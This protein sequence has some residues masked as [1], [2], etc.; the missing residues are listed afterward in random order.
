[1][2]N[3]DNIDFDL[4]IFGG[5]GDLTMRKLLPALY[6][7][8][9]DG[10][11]PKGRVI[12]VARTDLSRDSF[13]EQATRAARRYI[14]K[15]DQE[16]WSDFSQRLEYLCI[17][18][19]DI[20]QFAHLRQSLKDRADACRIFYLSTAPKLFHPICEGLAKNDLITPESRVVL[21]KPLGNNLASAREINQEIGAIFQESQ[22]YR[23][24]H[25]LGK[26]TVQNLIA[27]RF[28]NTLFEPLWQRSHI[29]DVQITVAE[30]IGV[31][32]RGD[33]YDQ[34]GALRDM[35]QNHLLQLLCIIAME[36]PTSIDSDAMR[37]EKRKVLRALKP[38][39]HHDVLRNTVRGQYRSGMVNGKTV[40]AYQDEEGVAVASGTETFVALKTEIDTWRWSGVP[41]FLRTG[42][43]MPEK[44]TEIVINFAGV[45]YSIFGNH[46]LPPANKLVIRLQPAESVKLFVLAKT[47]GDDMHLQPMALDLDLRQAYKMRPMQA[48]ER[49]LMDAIRGRLSLFMRRDEVEAAWSWIDPIHSGWT[50]H[51]CEPKTYSAGTWGPAAS[52]ALVGKQGFSW[53]EE[54]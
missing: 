24:D 19:T 14:P 37:D 20:A 39:A 2:Q 51:R 34:T 44:L 16:S 13:I 36:P 8:H 9:Q 35:V 18:A 17:D 11:L 38:I 45:P 22:I 4:I 33:F 48:Y 41:F 40:P 30:K 10:Q 23:I 1:M 5:T 49:L 27:L 32:T 6:A 53:N 15:L 47:P 52:S 31:G 43:R 46:E 7:R 50:E 21:E 3:T 54:T 29:R 25:Y 28:G 12:A 26:E 42:K